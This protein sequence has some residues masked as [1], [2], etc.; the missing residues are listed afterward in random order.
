MPLMS[1]GIRDLSDSVNLALIELAKYYEGTAA[2]RPSIVWPKTLTINVDTVTPQ[3]MLRQM[4]EEENSES[5]QHL[6]SIMARLSELVPVIVHMK[7]TMG[8]P[9]SDDY[10]FWYEPSEELFEAL[11]A[12]QAKIFRKAAM[13]PQCM[14]APAAVTSS[15]EV[16][17]CVEQPQEVLVQVIDLTGH[18][19]MSL[20]QHAES[21][22]NI[23]KVSTESLP[24][25]MYIISVQNNDGSQRTRRIWV[26][27]A[28][29]KQ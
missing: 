2:H 1:P 6:H 18:V 25:G 16:T 7:S 12:S 20:H 14:N 13:P 26:Q 21:G 24:S 27:N 19:V 3:D 4:D 11:P 28:H 29:P 10:I 15:A 17:Y 22:D 8:R 5:M 9:T 23:A